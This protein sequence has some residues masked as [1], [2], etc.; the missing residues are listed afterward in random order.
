MYIVKHK[1]KL[2]GTAKTV[3]EAIQLVLNE[4]VRLDP[5]LEV[6]ADSAESLVPAV[7]RSVAHGMW[8]WEGSSIQRA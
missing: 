7:E 6:D 1:K 4:W 3:K 8:K 2:L 5:E